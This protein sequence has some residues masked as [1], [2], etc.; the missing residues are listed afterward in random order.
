MLSHNLKSCSSIIH[1]EGKFGGKSN[2]IKDF[3]L[4]NH[5]F[6]TIVEVIPL[7]SIF[8]QKHLQAL[9]LK[10]LIAL[11]FLGSSFSKFCFYVLTPKVYTNSFLIEA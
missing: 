11:V 9:S 10:V 7:P 8:Q 3:P 5:T 2:W 6:Y 4:P 1:Q